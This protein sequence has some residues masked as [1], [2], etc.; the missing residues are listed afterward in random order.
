RILDKIHI[1][2]AKISFVGN[3]LGFLMNKVPNIDPEAYYNTRNSQ[4]V[5]AIAM[6][7]GRSFGFSLG[8]KL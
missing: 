7:I 3:N 2:G 4:G 6:P 1:K 8:I 5:E